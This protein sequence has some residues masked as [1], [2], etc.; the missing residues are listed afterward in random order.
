MSVNLI[1]LNDSSILNSRESRY[2]FIVDETYEYF[3]TKI[4]YR[5]PYPME[6]ILILIHIFRKSCF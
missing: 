2:K 4:S 5:S 6:F 3:Y 1:L